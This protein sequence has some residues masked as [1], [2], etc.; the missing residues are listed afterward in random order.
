MAE[1]LQSLYEVLGVTR[2]ASAQQI[3][4][5][6]LE[7]AKIFHPDSNFYSEICSAAL[8]N[9]NIARFKK[10]TEAY[11]TLRSPTLRAKYDASL[12]PPLPNWETERPSAGRATSGVHSRTWDSFGQA[13]AVQETRVEQADEELGIS[14]SEMMRRR[15]WWGR[16]SGGLNLIVTAVRAAAKA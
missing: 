7:L 4:E 6:F 10:I 9:Q 11:N 3:R 1:E 13:R 16:A 14:I 5:A 8:T 2:D 15:S 12:P